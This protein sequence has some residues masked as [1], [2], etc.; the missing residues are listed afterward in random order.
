MTN[1][2]KETIYNDTEWIKITFT[3]SYSS[4]EILMKKSLFEKKYKKIE[5]EFKNMEYHIFRDYSLNLEE[6][7]RMDET[8][9]FYLKQMNR[10][11]AL[12][13][14]AEGHDTHYDI[15]EL[16]EHF[17]KAYF[18]FNHRLEEIT[19]EFYE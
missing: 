4:G 13:R 1:K 18:N 9:N 7:T 10:Y 14:Y 3:S 5:K 16:R 19:K 2:E 17:D 15:K 8:A 12:L 11:K 6:T